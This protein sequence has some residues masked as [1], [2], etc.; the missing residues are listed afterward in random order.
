[1]PPLFRKLEPKKE[2]PQRKPGAG[3][4]EIQQLLGHNRVSTTDLYL[5]SLGN[6]SKEAIKKLEIIN[7]GYGKLEDTGKGINEVSPQSTPRKIRGKQ[8]N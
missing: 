4:T 8:K 2:A 3:T 6:G 1:M 5:K 7:P